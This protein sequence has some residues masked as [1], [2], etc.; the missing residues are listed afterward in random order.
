[1]AASKK[2]NLGGQS[3]EDIVILTAW[4]YYH[5]GLNQ[6]Q[7]ADKLAVSRASVVNY[8]NEARERGYIRIS[9]NE[10]VFLGHRL[11]LALCQAFNLTAA[12]VVPDDPD[13]EE[14]TFQRVARGAA[15]W[16]P[17]L[18]QPNDRLGVS[19]GKTIYEVAEIM[20]PVAIDNLVVSQLVGSM[21]TPYGFTA[22]I[23]S[24]H[25]A[26]KLSARCINLHAPAVMSDPELAARLR[27]EPII[28]AQLESLSQCNKA[29]FSSGSCNVDSHVVGSGV[30]TIEEL[31]WYVDKGARGV[32]CGRFIDADGLPIE[33]DL[34]DRMI[35]ITLD[36]LV[37]L[38]MGILVALGDDKVQAVLATL[39][40][41][42][43]THMVTSVSMAE[44][45][46][47]NAK[48]GMNG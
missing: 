32:L 24:A 28:S 6:N 21:A 29:L 31:N 18:L 33:G 15:H 19:W 38:D 30:A 14:A 4:L 22:E 48:P 20:E 46:L 5:D 13:D 23:C 39:N 1:M 3:G 25:V 40:G 12:Y 9:L 45:L 47:V 11:S 16:L 7:I 27:K 26:G 36:H 41:G 43:A 10:D 35:G 8:L 44:A 42:Y 2:K 37:G 17:R 34:G